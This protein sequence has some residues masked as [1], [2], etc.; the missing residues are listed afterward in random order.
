MKRSSTIDLP[1]YKKFKGYEKAL[2]IAVRRIYKE[3]TVG[4][5]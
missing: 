1:Q 3:L 5:P 4:L 2:E